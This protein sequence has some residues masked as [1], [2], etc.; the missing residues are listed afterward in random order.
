MGFWSNLFKG[1]GTVAKD[2]F[3][4]GTLQGLTLE[5]KNYIDKMDK[6]KPEEKEAMKKGVDL[7]A[8]RVTEKLDK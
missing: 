7:L 4:V 2:V 6:V 3:V 5:V 8:A 1:F